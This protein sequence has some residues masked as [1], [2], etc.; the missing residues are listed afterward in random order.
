MQTT[1][2]ISMTCNYRYLQPKDINIRHPTQVGYNPPIRRSQ[3]E[4]FSPIVGNNVER[5]YYND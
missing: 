1:I 3:E 5:F 4:K 2:Y